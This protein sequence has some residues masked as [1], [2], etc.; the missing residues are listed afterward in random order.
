MGTPNQSGCPVM[1]TSCCACGAAASNGCGL[2]RRGFLGGVGGAALGGL[3]LSGLTWSS[4]ASAAESNES[5]P[6]PRRTLVVKPILTYSLFKRAQQTSWRPWG[7]IQSQKDADD[8]V[9]RIQTETEKMRTQADF[10]VTFLPVSAIRSA[11]EF[12]QIADAKTADVLLIYASSGG[13][14]L[15]DAIGNSGKNV[16]FFLR[17]KSGP[18]SLWYEIISPY[19]L[20]HQTDHRTNKIV[21]DRDVVVDSLDQVVWRLRAL[22]GLKNAIASKIVAIGGPGGW[23]AV[24]SKAPGLVREHWK[25]DIQNVGYDELGKLIK[26]AMEDQ[27]AV[28]LAKK[29]AEEYLKQDGVKLETETTFVVNA[30]LL[31]Q[32]FRGLMAKAGTRAITVNNCMGTIMPISQTTACM[33]LSL[34]NDAGFLAFCES[35]FVVIPSGILMAGISGRPVFLND[36]TYPHDGII[37]LAHCTAPRKMDGKNL[38]PVRILTHFESDYGAAPKVEM[39]KGMKVSNILPDF[40]DERWVGL[41]GEITDVPFLP[42]CRSQIDIQFKPDSLKV[43]E[44]MPGF[45]WMSCYGDYMKEIGY[46]LSKTKIGWDDM[47]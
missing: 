24:G 19:H 11:S 38:D 4:T 35:D 21:S 28:N 44:N 43:A 36:P 47:G 15:L 9:T 26:A 8:E 25:M 17:H 10:P 41:M 37:T 33:T 18:V 45:H 39:Q 12:A 2:S 34:L 29:R 23:G 13:N 42:I 3:A 14:D 16:V 5:G 40:L 20:R 1:K 30:F 31:E 46:A 32:V 7:G 22:C 27:T 6:A